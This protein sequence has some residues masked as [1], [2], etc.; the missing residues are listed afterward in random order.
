MKVT[1]PSIRC[2]GIAIVVLLAVTSWLSMVA[3]GCLGQGSLQ[4]RVEEVDEFFR[5][6]TVNLAE[7]TSFIGTLEGFDFENAQFLDNTL[8]EIEMSRYA[9]QNV[10]E[11]LQAL[12]ELDYSGDLE[13]LGQY[14]NEYL[15]AMEG[16]LGELEDIYA[17]LE[18]ILKS[19]EPVLREE[20]VI[21]QMEAPQSD[22]EWLERL[23]RLDAALQLSVAELQKAEVPPSLQGY[24]AFFIDIFSTM[25]KLTGDLI[26]VVTGVVSNEELEN[27]PDFIRIMEQVEEYGS[28]VEELYRSLA[29]TRIDPYVEAVELEINRLYLGGEGGG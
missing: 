21:T 2:R 15:A 8:R 28:L 19:I 1:M 6:G 26:A 12:G 22:Q 7:T 4:S 13:Q 24:K 23:N 25:Y 16:A 27:N 20:A 9:A 18:E 14:I 5:Q 10:R 17:G 29:I 11:S 3:V